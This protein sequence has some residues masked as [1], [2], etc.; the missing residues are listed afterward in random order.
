MQVL[1]TQQT[2][3]APNEGDH[4]R[5]TAVSEAIRTTRTLAKAALNSMIDAAAGAAWCALPSFRPQG[6][7]PVG[8]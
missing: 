2:E 4:E 1:Y 3:E 6:R 5:R 7:V 8:A